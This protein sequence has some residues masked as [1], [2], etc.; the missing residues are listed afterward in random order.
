M[1]RCSGSRQIA[2]LNFVLIVCVPWCCGELRGR[3]KLAPRD[4]AR[5]PPRLGLASLAQITEPRAL[6]GA[7]VEDPGRKADRK[8]LAATAGPLLATPSGQ[9]SKGKRPRLE[10]DWGAS[11]NV[12]FTQ[13]GRK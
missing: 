11:A 1:M 2:N 5:K 13:R 6:A 7:P 3:D 9:M 8:R 12:H 10:P 4:R